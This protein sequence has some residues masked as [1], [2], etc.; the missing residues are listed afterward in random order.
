M[1]ADKNRMYRDVDVLTGIHPPR[2]SRHLQSLNIIAQYIRDEFQK[3]GLQ[4]DEQKWGVGGK[5]YKN[6]I[7]TYNGQAEKR[8]V[9][10]AHYD[11]CC[12]YPGA[13]D[14]ASGIAGLLETARLVGANRPDL[15]YGLEFVAYCL[16]EPPYFNTENMG[17]FV[18]AS[19]LIEQ[20]ADILGMICYEMIGYFSEISGSQPNPRPWLVPDIPDTGDFAMILGLDSAP[21]FNG[22]IRDL[23]IENEG[24]DTWMIELTVNDELAGL[25]DHKNYWRFGY[26]AVM[27]T[28]TAK[29]RNPNYHSETD[30]ID[31]LDF[32]R[33]KEVV[34][35]TYLAATGF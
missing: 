33:M 1:K 5:I 17:S 6:V 21:A 26:N 32:E 31:T 3:T 19:S 9:I 29:I 11:V 22:K 18:H 14:N 12:D 4:V 13:D 25:S 34:N 7:A 35:S 2:N 27:I 24:I 28:D 23:M 16:E 15:R 20:N 10:G 8:L 30:T